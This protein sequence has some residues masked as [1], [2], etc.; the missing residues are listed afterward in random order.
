MEANHDNRKPMKP[1]AGQWWYLPTVVA[2]VGVMFFFVLRVM[3]AMP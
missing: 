3:P 2:L 1:G